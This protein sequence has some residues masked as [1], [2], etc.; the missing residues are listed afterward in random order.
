[1]TLFWHLARLAASRSVRREA[2]F[3]FG[4][5]PGGGGPLVNGF[6]DVLA[7]EGAG[8]RLVVD[9]KT[10]RLEGAEPAAVVDRDYATQRV[11][12]ALA[13]LRDGAER[14]DVA[15][16]FLERPDAPVVR[17][18]SAADAPALAEHVLALARG[19]LDESY[20]VTPA[21]HRD[22]CG[23]CPGRRALCSHPESL[24]LRPA[25]APQPSAGSLAGR[26]GPS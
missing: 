22:L 25:P 18:F 5:E 17:S 23:D 21:P 2:G 9:Y 26:G 4:L 3:A 11:V 1:M 12:Y 16:C 7:S 6:V 14:V 20:P 15:H 24:T 8:A 10:D 13:A 19:V